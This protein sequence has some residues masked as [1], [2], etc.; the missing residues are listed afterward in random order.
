MKKN[1]KRNFFGTGDQMKKQ[2]FE[3][4]LELAK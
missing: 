3:L 4:C 2:A 1:L